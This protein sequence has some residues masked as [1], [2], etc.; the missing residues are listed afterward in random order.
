MTNRYYLGVLSTSST[1][2]EFTWDETKFLE[3]LTEK[4][5]RRVGRNFDFRVGRAQRQKC[6]RVVVRALQKREKEYPQ[7]GAYYA[8]PKEEVVFTV[9]A[10]LA[11]YDKGIE[12]I[13]EFMTGERYLTS[14]IADADKGLMKEKILLDVF[15]KSP[16]DKKLH[17][18]LFQ[19]IDHTA[20]LRPVMTSEAYR[21]I[22]ANYKTSYAAQYERTETFDI[23]RHLRGRKDEGTLRRGM[24]TFSVPATIQYLFKPTN[25]DFD[26]ELQQFGLRLN[27]HSNADY[28]AAE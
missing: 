25:G 24:L 3:G 4:E 12:R 23:T 9:T 18:A 14:H 2:P 17:E 13:G 7:Q 28:N 16:L 8:G 22:I 21:I 10:L 20:N 6:F 1:I 26:V 15:K 11:E 19:S 5:F 27:K